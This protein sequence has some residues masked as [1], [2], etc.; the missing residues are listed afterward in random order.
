M[1]KRR[2]AVWTEDLKG[3]A[4]EQLKVHD[5]DTD[6]GVYL[7]GVVFGVMA[8]QGR[9]PYPLKDDI[10]PIMKLGYQDTRMLID[11]VRQDGDAPDGDYASLLALP[12][13]SETLSALPPPAT[14]GAR[15]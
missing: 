4:V 7:L 15:I 5:T 8:A 13:S 9:L 1:A 2:I 11:R 14:R 3:W 10:S 12:C 6:N